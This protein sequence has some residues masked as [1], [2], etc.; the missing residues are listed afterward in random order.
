MSSSSKKSTTGTKKVSKPVVPSAAAKKKV[1][2]VG[3]GFKDVHSHLF[4]KNERKVA[5][6]QAVRPKTDLSRFV[7]WPRYVRIQRQRAILKK[8][9]KVPPA[10]NQF[11]KAL[12]KN[13]AA[14]LFRLLS[15]YRPES[16]EDKKQR[17][18]SVAESA[19]KG[20]EKKSEGAKSTTKPFFLKYGLNH[21]TDLIETKKARLV[22]IAHDVDPIEL[23]VWL[24]ALCRKMNVPYAI[25]KG[26]ARLGH[27]VHKKTVSA[28]AITEVRKEDQPKLDQ[29]ISNVRIQFNDNVS[30]RKKWGGGIMGVKANHVIRAREKAAAKELIGK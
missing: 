7:R 3:K 27:I 26:K 25:V 30:D 12:D 29:F 5:I 18:K 16:R 21:V 17:L 10:I 1:I 15:H 24:P 13:Q 4:S 22:V 9:L 19:V 6:G 11:A 14:N 8:R 2:K 23:V 28:V 20:D